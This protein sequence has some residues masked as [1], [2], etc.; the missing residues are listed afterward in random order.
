MVYA[1]RINDQTK[2]I[3]S[4]LINPGMQYSLLNRSI[5]ILVFFVLVFVALYYAKDFLIP[6]ALAGILSMLMLPISQ[7]LEKKGWPRGLAVLCCL[8]LLL[9]VIALLVFILSWQIA[10]LTEDLTNIQG[11]VKDFLANAQK[12]IDEHFG[13][14]PQE[15]NKIIE[16]QQQSGSGG[17]STAF[18]IF[19]FI[20]GFAADFVLTMVYIFLFIYFRGHLKTFILKLVPADNQKKTIKVI[21]QSCNVSQQYLGGLAMMIACLWVAYGIGFSLVGVKNALFFAVLCGVLEIIPFVGNLVGSSLALLMVIMQGGSNTM[22]LG[23][24]I[25]YAVIQFFQTYILEP[26]VVGAEVNINPLFTIMALVVGEMVWGLPGMIMAIPLLGMVKIICENIEP[27]K[28]YA[29]LIGEK[30]K[31]GERSWVQK[32]K[33]RF[34]NN[35]QAA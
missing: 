32:I 29:F 9:A 16:S 6:I 21:D 22:I 23:V 11:K 5:R 27:L 20:G 19:A 24:I 35:R 3:S 2:N 31:R 13:I 28:P 4:A 7:K 34:T 15:Q 25:V 12:Y 26:L 18:N 33:Q 1:G 10:G 30:K 8:L 14:T 17:S